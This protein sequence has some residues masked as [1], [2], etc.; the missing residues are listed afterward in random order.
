MGS[1]KAPSHALTLCLVASIL[2]EISPL[3]SSIAGADPVIATITVGAGHHSV[4]INPIT[5]HVYTAVM[6]SSTVSV[7]NTASTTVIATIHLPNNYSPREVAVDSK[8]NYIYTAN[9][10]S[11]NLSVTGAA[12]NNVINA[13]QSSGSIAE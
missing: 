11:N 3:F 8:R 12:N 6:F 4:L 9:V 13:V 1:L 2:S 7:I 5:G 10:Y